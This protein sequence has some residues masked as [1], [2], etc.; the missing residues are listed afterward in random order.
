MEERFVVH[1]V[2]TA[3][4]E[5]AGEIFSIEETRVEQRFL[6]GGGFGETESDLFR[7]VSVL[8][9]VRKGRVVKEIEL[10]SAIGRE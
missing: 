8:F 6:V 4:A 9:P 10:A 7:D 5:R 2:G 3:V 1:V